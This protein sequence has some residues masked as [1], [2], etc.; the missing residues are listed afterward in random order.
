MEN[1]LKKNR[2]SF[3]T[4]KQNVISYFGFYRFYLILELKFVPDMVLDS[5]IPVSVSKSEHTCHSSLSQ[6]L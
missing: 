4:L 2:N 6:K 3:Y 5:E 1:E